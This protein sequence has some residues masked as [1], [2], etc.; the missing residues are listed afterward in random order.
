MRPLRHM[1]AT[2]ILIA[3]ATPAAS[4]TFPWTAQQRT[5][6]KACITS[7][8]RGDL[9]DALG[10]LEAARA[11]ND[12]Q[13]CDAWAAVLDGLTT[14][15]SAATLRFFESM[16]HDGFGGADLPRATASRLEGR[17]PPPASLKG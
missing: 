16:L 7:A 15:G 2:A 11:S 13:L 14:S 1:A 12:P 8:Q 5:P 6:A 3:L 10:Q 17:A 9:V 4:I